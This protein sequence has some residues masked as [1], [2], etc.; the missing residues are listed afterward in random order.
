MHTSREQLSPGLYP[1]FKVL[2]RRNF[3]RIVKQ[4]RPW[5]HHK[6]EER[7]QAFADCWRRAQVEVRHLLFCTIEDLPDLDLEMDAIL[8]AAPANADLEE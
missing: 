7:L 2:T 1:A 8:S 5:E 4:T 6:R 3:V